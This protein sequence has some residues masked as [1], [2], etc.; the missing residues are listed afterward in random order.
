MMCLT[1]VLPSSLVP[2]ESTNI[3][4]TAVFFSSSVRNLAVS[5]P[6]GMINQ[7]APAMSKEIMP[8]KKVS[9][10]AISEEG[11]PTSKKYTF[12]HL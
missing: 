4:F 7:E 10:M 11:V 9:R 1:R 5:G 2:A 6:R 8:Y 3:L 12:R